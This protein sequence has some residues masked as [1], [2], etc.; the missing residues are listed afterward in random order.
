ML[1]HRLIR[2]YTDRHGNAVVNPAL[3]VLTGDQVI[4][5]D[6]TPLAW[7]Q[8]GPGFPRVLD[9]RAEVGATEGTIELGADYGL[10]LSGPTGTVTVRE[11]LPLTW[12]WDMLPSRARLSIYADP[13]GTLNGNEIYLL[14]DQ[15]LD[16]FLLEELSVCPPAVRRGCMRWTSAWG[17]SRW[18]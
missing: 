14:E 10:Q 18:G 9:D 8:R 16:E 4:G 12:Q 15:P 11:I 5:L 7:D 3:N 1:T 2:A 17:P 13:D 6:G